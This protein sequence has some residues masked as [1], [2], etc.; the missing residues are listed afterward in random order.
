[1]ASA[2]DTLQMTV[3][4]KGRQAAF[5]ERKKKELRR[6]Q[7]LSGKEDVLSNSTMV[8]GLVELW[9]TLDAPAKLTKQALKDAAK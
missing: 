9:M 2:P 3:R 7:I 8:Q 4:L 5:W 1:M 6:M